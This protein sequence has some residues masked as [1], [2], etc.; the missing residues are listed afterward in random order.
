MRC[1]ALAALVLVSIAPALGQSPGEADARFAF[2]ATPEGVLRLDRRSGEVSLCRSEGVSWACRPAADERPPPN[3]TIQRLERENA[4]LRRRLAEAERAVGRPSQ[5]DLDAA[6]GALER[7][8][9]RT[10][11]AIERWRAPDGQRT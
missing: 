9:D 1:S 3:E 6:M 4:E 10:M 7:F 8:L 5:Q 2:Q 11:R